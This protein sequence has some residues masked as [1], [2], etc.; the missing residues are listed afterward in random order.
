MSR[1]PILLLALAALARPR[2]LV[3]NG[4]GARWRGAPC[5]SAVTGFVGL[6]AGAV[7]SLAWLLRSRTPT[8]RAIERRLAALERL[9]ATR[10]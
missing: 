8:L 4:G 2:P 9:L 10:G 1:T 5:S 7:S 3:A 6:L